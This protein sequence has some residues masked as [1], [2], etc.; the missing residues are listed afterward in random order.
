MHRFLSGL[1]TVALSTL[2]FSAYAQAEE[3]K[4]DDLVRSKQ[5]DAKEAATEAAARHFYEFWD[6]GDPKHLDMAIGPSFTDHTLPDGRP[7][8][9]AGPAFASRNFREAVPDLRVEIKKLV[10]SG[11]Y[12]TVHMVFTGHYSGEFGGSKGSGQKIEFIATDL[13]K[14]D[15]GKITDNWHIE[16]NLTL[17]KQL[18]LVKK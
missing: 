1:A 4:I 16:D 18:G 14:V 10:L 3:L 5:G 6:T 15:G 13:I 7:Q 11:S 12:A 2:L 8:G 17:F 9:P